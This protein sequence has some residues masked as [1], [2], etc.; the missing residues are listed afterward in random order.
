MPDQFLQPEMWFNRC[1]D[2][3]YPLPNRHGKGFSRSVCPR[4]GMV[5]FLEEYQLDS[6][7]WM[8]TD[9]SPGYVGFSYCISGRVNWSID[10]VPQEF[11]SSTG[12]CEVLYS[13]STNGKG[14]YLPGEPLVLINI[15]LCPELLQSFFEVPGQGAGQ[16][17]YLQPPVWK[18]G[19]NYRKRSIAANE[20]K[21]LQE[22]LRAPCHSMADRLFVQSKAMELVS[23]YINDL[24][25][26]DQKCLQQPQ[27]TNAQYVTDRAKAILRSSMQSPPTIQSLARMIGTNET[28]LKKSFR[29]HLGI[30]VF[31]YLT[32]CRMQRACELLE[33]S[34][35]TISQIGAEVGY[36]ERTHFTRAFSRYFNFS[37][38]Q[39][40]SN[41]HKPPPS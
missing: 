27:T 29:T 34:N 13:G 2:V 39:Y 22:L 6:D 14:C 23:F 1:H 4:K 5:L 31:G 32:A 12:Q 28:K 21:V 11:T 37:P 41:L 8:V 10:G 15:M 33:G 17:K 26:V 25:T 16:I 20:Q 36:S 18:E 7:M 38:S 24:E 9:N 40:R 19:I 3:S 30:T 35:L